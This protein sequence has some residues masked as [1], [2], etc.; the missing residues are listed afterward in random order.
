M[1]QYISKINGETHIL[2]GILFID[3]YKVIKIKY[4]VFELNQMSL[5]V[6]CFDWLLI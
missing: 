2:L 4:D 3:Q 6:S 1:K 5:I